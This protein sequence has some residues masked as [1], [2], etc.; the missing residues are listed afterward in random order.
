MIKETRMKSRLSIVALASLL[1]ACN[2]K[3]DEIHSS[4][5]ATHVPVVT[6]TNYIFD[7]DAP[8]GV[9]PASEMDRLNAWF[10]TLEVDYGDSIYVDGADGPARGQVAAVAGNYGILL[11]QGAPVTAGATTPNSVRV[12]LSRAEARVPG[13]PDW[14]GVSEPNFNNQPVSNYGCGV[15]G[16]LAM[17]VANAQD[18][19][20]GHAGPSA[21]DGATAAKAINL[22]RS[23]PLTAIIDGQAKR[24]FKKPETFTREK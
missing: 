4:L 17:Q 6:Q 1:A 11:S 3:T 13:C 22:Y 23:W 19:V 21:E 5:N 18:L 14:S 8:G 12:V 10:S 15:S 16:G 7:V 24:P 2:G 9:M 20:H